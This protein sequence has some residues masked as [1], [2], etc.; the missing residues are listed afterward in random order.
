M[1]PQVAS[2]DMVLYR[3]LRYVRVSGHKAH[4]F[5]MGAHA[6]HASYMKFYLHRNWS[7]TPCCTVQAFNL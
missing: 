1:I 5:H 4:V 3:C 6:W 2:Y 7:A